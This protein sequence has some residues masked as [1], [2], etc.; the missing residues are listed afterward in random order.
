MQRLTVLLYGAFAYGVFLL[1]FLYFVAFTGNLQ[2]T[3]LVDLLP[4][5]ATLVPYS[6]DAGRETGPLALA[7]TVNL[8]LVL[9]FGLQHSVMARSG[10]KAWL[11]RTL[12]PAAERSTFVL[13]ASAVLILLM[14]QWRPVPVM[15]WDA[16]ST[17]GQVIGWTVFAA[18]F[19]I[20]LLSTYLIDHFELF[21]LKQVWMQFRKRQ[22]A[23]TQFMT[24]LLY[25]V[26][27]HPLYFGFLLA[28]WGTPGMSVGRLVF[29][30]SMTAYILIAIRF[31]ERD[32]VRFHGPV[33]ERYRERVPMILPLPG[34]RFEV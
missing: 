24:P 21:G 30:S 1:T 15:L 28:F 13:I 33:Y 32:L 25:Q 26:V 17:A 22:P 8:G 3:G 7:V 16:Q 20:V 5:L 18:G 14:W 31:E 4:V 27:R 11:H 23:M 29:A 10:F 2:L 12:P 9:L 34:R 6:L 19:A